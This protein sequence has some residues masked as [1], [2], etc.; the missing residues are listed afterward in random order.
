LREFLQ[1]SSVI[2][3]K[4]LR[5]YRFEG[6]ISYDNAHFRSLI[7]KILLGYV[8]ADKNEW[9]STL[10]EKRQLYRQFVTELI[11][12]DTSRTQDDDHVS[13]I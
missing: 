3:A 6:G 5:Q 9:E 4:V 11:L 10:A 7:W 8:S 1:K 12:D 2:D 13:I